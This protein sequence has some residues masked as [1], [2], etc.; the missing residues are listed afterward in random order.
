LLFHH[1]FYIYANHVCHIA[2]HFHQFHLKQDRTCN[3]L[4]NMHFLLRIDKNVI[5]NRI[6]SWEEK[7][8]IEKRSEASSPSW[9]DWWTRCRIVWSRSLPRRERRSSIPEIQ[10]MTI[11]HQLF[12]A[13]LKWWTWSLWIERK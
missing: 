6:R 3:E 1:Q 5:P 9:T 4:K 11:Q 2:I 12:Q 8:S 7:W 13:R 10:G